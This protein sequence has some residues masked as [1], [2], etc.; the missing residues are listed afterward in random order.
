MLYRSKVPF[1]LGFAGGGTDV[2][3]YSD[4]YGGAVLN[5]TINLY[6]YAT[7]RPLLIMA[8]YVYIS[9]II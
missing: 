9:M 7:I 2:S 8:R 4:L 5:V 6:V 3:P 1:R